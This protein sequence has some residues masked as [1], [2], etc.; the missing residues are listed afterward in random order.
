MS[1]II[2]GPNSCNSFLVISPNIASPS[3]NQYSVQESAMVQTGNIF[4]CLA[5]N[6]LQKLYQHDLSK[7]ISHHFS[8]NNLFPLFLSLF[9]SND[10]SAAELL[11]NFHLDY[12]KII[13]RPISC[14]QFV[15]SFI[16]FFFL[17]SL[18]NILCKCQGIKIARIQFK[19]QEIYNLTERIQTT[20]CIPIDFKYNTK[21]ISK[22]CE[23]PREKAIH[24]PQGDGRR[25][26]L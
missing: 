6:V 9:F 1:S 11:I 26:S 17:H 19:S 15:L 21:G 24:S 4:L 5:F 2:P 20:T 3:H 7:F 18:N 22:I 13:T 10:D 25:P 12:F 16:P 8:K 14:V 23:N